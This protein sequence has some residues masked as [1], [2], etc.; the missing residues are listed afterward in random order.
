MLTSQVE[1]L[2]ARIKRLEQEPG[3]DAPILTHF[4]TQLANLEKL[5]S[6]TTSQP[7]EDRYIVGMRSSETIRSK[8]TTEPKREANTEQPLG[9]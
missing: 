5:Q 6:Q 1:S 8:G 4:R 3:K 7:W 9:Q 2:R